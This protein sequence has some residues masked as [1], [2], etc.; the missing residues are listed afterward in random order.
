MASTVCRREIIITRC[1]PIVAR[2]RAVSKVLEEAAAEEARRTTRGHGDNW[3]NT[4]QLRNESIR[5]G[6]HRGS[7][8]VAGPNVTS[9]GYCQHPRDALDSLS[10]T[11]TSLHMPDTLLMSTGCGQINAI[12]AT[13]NLP[14]K[15]SW[16]KADAESLNSRFQCKNFSILHFLN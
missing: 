8:P 9:P 7:F 5:P 4:K 13:I 10:K 3:E 6:K 16:Q 15:D 2:K 1:L 11:H 12:P 14:P